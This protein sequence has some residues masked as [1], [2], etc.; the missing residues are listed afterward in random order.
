[1]AEHL[2]GYCPNQLSFSE[3][4]GMVMMKWWKTDSI[5]NE[6]ILAGMKIVRIP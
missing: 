3:S 1:M 4:C 6:S 5:S 2:K